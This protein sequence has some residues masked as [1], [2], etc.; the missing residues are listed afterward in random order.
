[1]PPE[2]P[3]P[4]ERPAPPEQ[5]AP[6]GRPAS[7][8]AGRLRALA[9]RVRPD[10]A[11][12]RSS[13]DFRLLWSAGLVTT[14]GSFLTYVSVPLQIK[15]LTGS[16]LAVGLVGAAELVPLVVCG[17][18]GGALADALD[19]R[20][21]VLATEAGLGLLSL[22]LLANALLPHPLLWPLYAVAALTA[23]L[24]GLQRPSLD[25][26]TPRIVAHDQLTAAAALNSLRWQVG[27][28]AGPSLAGVVAATA[29]VQVA[30][31]LDAATFAVSLL[32]LARMRAAPPPTGAERPSLAAVAEGLRYAWSRKELLGTYAVDVVAMLFAFPNAVFPFLADRLHAPWA[33]GLM[34]AA[35]SA[36]GLA[37]SA[38]SGWASRVHRQG[39]MVVAA[40]ALWGAAVACAGL[41]GRVWAVLLLLALAGGADMVSGL[42]R[43][44]MWNQSIPDALRGRLAGVELL[45][46]SLG[47]Q[48]GQVRA[49][50]TAAA[51]GVRTSVWS[52]G[53]LC[54]AGVAALAASL[55]RL[56]AYDDRTDPHAA[57]VR[58]E[59]ERRAAAEAAE[60][61]AV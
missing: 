59:R 33:L 3:A 39:R 21:M 56:L 4:S 7:A 47:P 23:A 55:P 22:L 36:G 50:G 25:A 48:L 24:D 37:V 18:W 40:A 14:F 44:T 30:Y 19:R 34:Y 61:A 42:G 20:R 32:L 27:A 45:S 58:A 9:R 2:Q 11:P 1:M 43:S 17:L 13:R 31:A 5:P 41:A 54:V 6:S 16:S 26:L 60:P 10:L 53:L 28:I 51:F 57:A 8:P 38:T 12:W 15:D 46:Y 35:S 29:G 49:G 52:G